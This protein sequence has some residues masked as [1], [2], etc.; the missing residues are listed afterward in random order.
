MST[1][2]TGS[3]PIGHLH[4]SVWV[5]D[6]EG[7][8][9]AVEVTAP[10][11]PR[12]DPVGDPPGGFLKPVKE[13]IEVF[14]DV[15]KAST[16]LLRDISGDQ[17]TC[18]I[19]W[20]ESEYETEAEDATV[21]TEYDN[22][23]Y[24]E[25]DYTKDTS[26]FISRSSNHVTF[27]TSTQFTPTSYAETATQDDD[28]VEPPVLPRV[29]EDSTIGSRSWEYTT[30]G[31]ESLLTEDRTL[32]ESKLFGVFDIPFCGKVQDIIEQEFFDDDTFY[33]EDASSLQSS[34]ASMSTMDT[35]EIEGSGTRDVLCGA[36][37][38][39]GSPPVSPARS[40][41]MKA[42]LEDSSIG[43]RRRIWKQKIREMQHLHEVLE[44]E[45]SDA[46]DTSR[47]S[48]PTSVATPIRQTSGAG[49]LNSSVVT[50]DS[51]YGIQGPPSLRPNRK[52]NVPPSVNSSLDSDKTRD[53]NHSMSKEKFV[54]TIADD[55][56]STTTSHD[57]P[58]S[59][60][61]FP[62][63]NAAVPSRKTVRSLLED[64]GCS[65]PKPD[66]SVL[67]VVGSDSI[68]ELTQTTHE[69][70]IDFARYKKQL[71]EAHESVEATLASTRRSALAFLHASEKGA[72]Q[73]IE[74]GMRFRTGSLATKGDEDYFDDYDVK[75]NR[76]PDADATAWAK[77]MATGRSKRAASKR[78]QLGEEDEL[79]P[80]FNGIEI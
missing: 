52:R 54:E 56:Q 44:E 41:R 63:A 17:H 28:V 69:Q 75:K 80:K 11:L 30:D 68:E 4:E 37:K 10:S 58:Q 42:L 79:I 74:A 15:G 19:D 8:R 59:I 71:E 21:E 53:V 6:D 67:Q 5:Q 20:S 66:D 76:N 39:C 25:E 24:Q 38:Q 70:H 47:E 13:D 50:N 57:S 34:I 55:I 9:S 46:N 7:S 40:D 35:Q 18:N 22:V 3:T 49:N 78:R 26:T 72:Q 1:I 77:K 48:A 73:L 60:L 2:S 29:T 62:G 23:E 45:T 14:S 33:S 43:R 31:E 16:I 64:F 27:D 65:G 36:L 61:D 32:K 12:R 51:S